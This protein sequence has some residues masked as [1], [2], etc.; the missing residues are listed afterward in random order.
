MPVNLMTSNIFLDSCAFDPKY[1]PEDKASLQIFNL[2]E[3]EKINLIIT[4]SNLKEIG[5]LNHFAAP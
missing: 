4:H 5:Y 2:Y 1:H 3:Q